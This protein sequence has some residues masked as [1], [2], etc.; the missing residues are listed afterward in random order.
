MRTITE[1]VKEYG[2]IWVYLNGEVVSRRFLRDAER[3]GF[4]LSNGAPPTETKWGYVM[5]VRGDKTLAHL[6]LF[7]WWMSFHGTNAPVG[8]KIDYERYAED[9]ADYICRTC[10]FKQ[11]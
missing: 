1:L 3:E 10:H 9:E 5:A 4:S 6:P 7:I 8:A 2:R 11:V